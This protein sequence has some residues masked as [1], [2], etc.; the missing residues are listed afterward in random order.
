[1]RVTDR[2]DLTTAER[3]LH[4]V[5][6]EQRKLEWTIEA[7]GDAK[8]RINA[9]LFEQLPGGT[10]LDEMEEFACDIFTKLAEAW[11]RQYDRLYK[12]GGA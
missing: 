9:F 3:I 12:S 5:A 6:E 8:L 10:S 4:Q 11:G 1:M 7:L 2:N